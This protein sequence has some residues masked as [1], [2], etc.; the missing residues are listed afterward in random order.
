[1]NPDVLIVGA[2]PVG[3]FTAIEMK[4]H[5]PRLNITILERNEEYSRHH[6]LH[7]EK[8]SLENS[9]AYTAF[10][11]VRALNGF[12]PTSEIEATFLQLAQELGVDIQRGINITNRKTLLEQFPTAHTI[13][14]ADGAHSTIRKQF[15]GDEKIIDNNL[16]Y[17]VELKYQA[18]GATSRLPVITYVPALGQIAHLLTENV[19]KLKNGTTPVSLFIF[20]DR[21]T[22][23]EIRKTKN[24]QLKDLQN[25]NKRMG[26]LLN[27]IRPWLSLRRVAVGEE[28][29]LGSEKINGVA[30]NIFQSAHFAK[31][32]FGKSIYLV[33]DAAAGVPFFRALNAGL[34]AATLTAKTIALHHSPNLDQLNDE[35]SALMYKEI[36]RA[37]KQNAKVN[38]GRA[39][40]LVLSNASKITSG[41][42]LKPGEE[43]AMLNARIE[44]PSLFRRHPRY[45]MTLGWGLA[46]TTALAFICFPTLPLAQ[47]VLYSVL[48]GI[49]IAGLSALLFKIMLYLRDSIKPPPIQRLVLPLP[50]ELDEGARPFRDLGPTMKKA[51]RAT[52]SDVLHFNSPLKPKRGVAAEENS[53]LST[54]RPS[55][56]ANCV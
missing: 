10:P 48:G 35:L 6:I 18:K 31:R 1:M 33:G 16:Q 51:E 7:L 45:L 30:L 26:T 20:V 29:I 52:E 21:E 55:S 5:N 50:W 23:D 36:K 12:V 17:I 47:A 14:G 49:A 53:H 3:L 32:L 40:N 46:A 38:W 43:A 34:I 9:K 41:A 25:T 54:L 4:L 24:A 13:I 19:G 37:K 8:D 22:Y 28:I 2:G 56:I 11:S 15:F 27:T 42:L 44:R 39:L